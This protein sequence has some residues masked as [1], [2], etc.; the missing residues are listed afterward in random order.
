[1]ALIYSGDTNGSEPTS[2]ICKISGNYKRSPPIML[3]FFTYFFSMRYNMDEYFAKQE[4]LF[5]DKAVKQLQ[6]CG[7][8]TPSPYFIGEI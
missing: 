4:A 8:K 1:M 3:R 2:M 7:Y 5:Y 6:E